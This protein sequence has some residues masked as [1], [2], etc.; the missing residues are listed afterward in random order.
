MG[1]NGFTALMPRDSYHGKLQSDSRVFTVWRMI[2]AA[3]RTIPVGR[4][5]GETAADDSDGGL[6]DHDRCSRHYPARRLNRR[7]SG[8]FRTT[9]STE[10]ARLN[11]MYRP[12]HIT[13]NRATRTPGCSTSNRK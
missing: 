3:G 11:R 5:H 1:A 10:G 13:T 4:R 8:D 2:L 7:R 6:G 12:Y 9:N